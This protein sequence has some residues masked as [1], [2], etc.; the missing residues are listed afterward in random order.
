MIEL[1]DSWLWAAFVVVGLLMI[2][3]ELFIGVE[4]GFDLVMLGSALILGSLLTSFA[5]S[6]LVTVICVSALCMLYVGIGR[7]Y[8]K[9]KMKVGDTKTNVD[10]IIGRGGVV[11]NS[12]GKNASGLVR[13]GNEDWRARSERN[14]YIEEGDMITVIDVDGVTLIVKREE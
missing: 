2:L 9:A 12:I 7:K 8:I 14:T 3:L 13:I 4:T 5:D 1:L 6:W 11:K 10:A